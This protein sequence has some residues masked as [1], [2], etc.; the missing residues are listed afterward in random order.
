MSEDITLTSGATE[1]VHGTYAAAVLHW[2]MGYG[3]RYDTITA[4]SADNRKRCLATAVRH[5]NEQTWGEDADTFAERDAITEFATAQYE[6][7]ALIADDPDVVSPA[8]TSSNIASLSAGS[9][10]IE[11]FNPEDG[12]T[13]PPVLMR[14]VGEYLSGGS[15]GSSVIGG[16][17]NTGACA[18]PFS[19]EEDYDP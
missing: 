1:T 10:G 3:D 15:T 18:S 2:A 9:A 14:L 4:L 19:A 5:L 7:A 16:F 11:F 17:G 13:L 12:D 8:D 6:L